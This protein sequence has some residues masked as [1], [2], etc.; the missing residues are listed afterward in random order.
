MLFPDILAEAQKFCQSTSVR[1]DARIVNSKSVSH[2]VFWLLGVLTCAGIL[3]WQLVVIFMRYRS[4]PVST[5]ILQSK[6]DDF[7]TFPDITICNLKDQ[8]TNSFVF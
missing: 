7:A 6:N 4:Y 8:V 2:G 5:V 3:T 1:G